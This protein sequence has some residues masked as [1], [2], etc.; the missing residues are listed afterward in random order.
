MVRHGAGAPR[1]GNTAHVSFPGLEGEH[2]VLALDMRG[3]AVSAG[4]ACKA[5]TSH[6]S[7]VLL[8]MGVSREIAQGAVR[9]SLG[10]ATTDA[11]IDRVVEILPGAVAGLRGS[12]AVRPG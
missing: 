2:L 1:I 3:I 12:S 10:R 7:H 5:G 6:P 4:P 9:L 11:E 8:A